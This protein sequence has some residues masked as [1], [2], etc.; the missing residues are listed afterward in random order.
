M[1]KIK[2]ISAEYISYI[3]LFLKAHYYSDIISE[4]LNKILKCIEYNNYIGNDKYIVQHNLLQYHLLIK[5]LSNV[6]KYFVI[7]YKYIYYIDLR[8]TVQI[9]CI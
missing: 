6:L 3:T 4:I 8:L 9:N 2:Y 1:I 7:Y 5:Y